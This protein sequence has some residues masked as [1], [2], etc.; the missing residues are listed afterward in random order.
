MID[1]DLP[2]LQPKDT[3][4]HLERLYAER[5]LHETYQ[6]RYGSNRTLGAHMAPI[7]VYRGAYRRNTR[8]SRKE[9]ILF[10][11]LLLNNLCHEFINNP[12]IVT[13]INN[14]GNADFNP[15]ANSL[16]Y[17]TSHTERSL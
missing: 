11:L 12:N 2:I 13:S 17:I 14:P 7:S 1:I 16:K 6:E 5:V 15:K 4:N 9:G 8:A 10:Y 3:I